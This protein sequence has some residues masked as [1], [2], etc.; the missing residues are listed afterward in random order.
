MCRVTAAIDPSGRRSIRSGSIIDTD[1]TPG[2]RPVDRVHVPV[3]VM[4]ESAKAVAVVALMSASTITANPA[5]ATTI[6][7]PA[8]AAKAGVEVV[9][10]AGAPASPLNTPDAATVAR[11]SEILLDVTN[12]FGVLLTPL[13]TLT[14]VVA[15]AAVRVATI[16]TAERAIEAMNASP[17][18]G[19][20][21]T[22][23]VRAIDETREVKVLMTRTIV[24]ALAIAT[25][26][27]GGMPTVHRNGPESRV[28]SMIDSPSAIGWMIVAST[29]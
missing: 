11:T 6:D 16:V 12:S 29:G 1:D 17:T 22:L 5:G 4:I 25:T 14:G 8:I 13:R 15:E 3:I 10:D 9:P 28:I 2:G 18:A 24:E 19:M 7:G 27:V 23:I 21:T 20:R 26:G